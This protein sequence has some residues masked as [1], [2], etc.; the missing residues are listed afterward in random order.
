MVRPL[1]F[2]VGDR[3]VFVFAQQGARGGSRASSVIDVGCGDGY[4]LSKL[5]HFYPR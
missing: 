4:F 5:L 3:F 1:N 2:A